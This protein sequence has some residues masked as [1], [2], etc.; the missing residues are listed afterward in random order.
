MTVPHRAAHYL[1]LGPKTSSLVMARRS[2]DDLPL[3][4]L[5][6]LRYNRAGY[7][8]RLRRSVIM[9]GPPT[10]LRTWLRS[11]PMVVS[12]SPIPHHPR[13]YLMDY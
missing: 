1:P 4:G 12:S 2:R 11:W 5:S 7:G 3:L 9:V 6:S 13:H 8:R 10:P